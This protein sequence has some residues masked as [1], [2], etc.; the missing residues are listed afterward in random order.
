ME[1]FSLIAMK[2]AEQALSAF[3]EMENIM[4]PMK[5]IAKNQIAAQVRCRAWSFDF[6]KFIFTK[7]TQKLRNIEA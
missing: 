1:R 4:N 5:I 6:E 2:Q 3:P 7:V